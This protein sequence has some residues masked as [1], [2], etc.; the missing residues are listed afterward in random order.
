MK[1]CTAKMKV[2]ALALAVEG[3]L[4]AMSMPVHADDEQLAALMMPTNFMEFG[5]LYTPQDS[6]KFG[7][8]SG[9]NKSGGYLNGNFNIRGG[10]A[11]GGNGTKRWE[12]RGSDLGLTSRSAG[13][14][15]SDQ[16]NWSFGINYDQL[17]H[18]GSDTFQT[19]Y[20]GTMGGNVFTL[21]GF[22]AVPT[23][24]PGTRT[25]T[26]TQL[27]QFHSMDLS[28]NRDN[29]SIIASRVLNRQWDIKVDFN[30][31]DQSGAKLQSFGTSNF[32]AANA[33]GQKIALLPMPTNSR[34]E[35]ATVALNWVGDM[36]HATA[37]YYGSFYRDNNN[38]FHFDNYTTTAPTISN[39]FGTPPS[40]SFHQLNLTGGYAL[41]AR[42]KLA[43]GLSYAYNSQDTAYAYDVTG[44]MVTPSPTASL[45][46][47]VATTHADL[48]LTDQATKNLALTAGIKYDDRNNRTASN[49]YNS[50]AI[51]GANIYNYPNTPLSIKRTQVE[52]AGDY[53]VDPKQKIR[54]AI[55][56]DEI[57]RQCNQYAVG[58]G[59]PA[60]APG[61]NCVTAT[62]TRDNKFNATYRLKA[63]DDVNF[64]IGYGFSARR[65]SFDENA[66]AAFIE[67]G[68]SL[69]GA[70]VSGLNA[71]D[72]RGFHPFF[73]SSRNQ[74]MLKT[75]VS[76]QATD[77][78]S[79]NAAARYTDDNYLSTLGVQKGHAW[80]IDLDSSYN[81]REQGAVTV[82]FT[83]Q[84][85]T[86]DVTD[87]QRSP[88]LAPS[89]ATAT[90]IAIPSG[91]T[92]SNFLKDTDVTVGLNLKQGGLMGGK[93]DL[94]GDLTYSLG[95][96]AY[97]TQLNYQTTTT[98]GL[99]CADPTIFSC[100][101]LPDV[102]NQMMQF[103][104]TGN[105][106]LEK[107]TKLSLGYL[108]RNLRSDDFYYNAY[109]YS[110]TATG[111][112]PTNQL[113]P[114]YAVNLVF[115]SFIYSFK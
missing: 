1:T 85:R 107:N 39:T 47:S 9:L 15:M 88:F 98:G 16:G 37:A 41:S 113:P 82:Y 38:G 21:P 23:A 65:T 73:E 115:A 29:T 34:T 32:G 81:Y 8:Y 5:F 13:A 17:T 54:V 96:S 99:T 110:F 92:F 20:Q 52:L 89:A 4:V 80:G 58:G 35:T 44:V 51:D 102:R 75:G 78:L 93:L 19:P 50:K 25:L 40:N 7:E 100:G 111:V 10:D 94:A 27:G 6:A 91:A 56:Y 31:L 87:M 95:R 53:R 69:P 33:N 86:R 104:L 72:Y 22:G 26:G 3:V 71:G 83:V 66:R 112:L 68:A 62:S 60:Y 74:N 28:N 67:T 49:I 76:W 108:Y 84:E 12:L 18:Y 48:K 45:N 101:S 46:G 43:G 77:M 59:T 42:T 55:S 114:S 106:K 11:Y 61:T 105:Y 57:D 36:G 103:K 70:A 24:A 63:S 30:H 64:N 109:Q 2:R 97:M 79:F 90:A 14:T